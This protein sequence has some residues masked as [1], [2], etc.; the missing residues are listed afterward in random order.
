MRNPDRLDDF[1]ERMKKKHKDKI[2][3][4]RFLQ[5]I[6]NFMGWVYSEYKR[7]PFYIEDADCINLFEGYLDEINKR[8][9]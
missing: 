7:D 8:S 9:I 2:P 5:T 3:D 4:W 1:Y 6:S